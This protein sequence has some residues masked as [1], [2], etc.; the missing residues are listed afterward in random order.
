MINHDFQIP[1]ERG[2]ACTA[3]KQI[4]DFMSLASWEVILW[5]ESTLRISILWM[6]WRQWKRLGR[7]GI[8]L[9]ASERDLNCLRWVHGNILLNTNTE[10][11]HVICFICTVPLDTWVVVCLV[12]PQD[13]FHNKPTL[14]GI[15]H[16]PQFG[17]LLANIATI[18]CDGELFPGLWCSIA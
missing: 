4:K 5:N 3:P 13:P 10:V 8:F 9:A 15:E 16:F 14:L 17:L 11:W 1:I 7:K 2:S 12:K 18:L 6:I